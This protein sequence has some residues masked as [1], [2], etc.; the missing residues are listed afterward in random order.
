MRALGIDLGTKRIGVAV[1]DLTGTIAN[2]LVV[3]ERSKSWRHDLNRIVAL[4]TDEEAECIVV[5]MPY[6]LSGKVGPAARGARSQAEALA[7]LTDVPVELFDE[8]L[9]TVTAH[10][11]LAEGGVDGR[12]RRGLVDKVAAAVMLQAWLDARVHAAT[13]SGGRAPARDGEVGR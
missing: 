4:A 7:T 11:A 8:R 9:T 1:S 3:I 5:G 12:R 6:E 13:R 10:R 2:P